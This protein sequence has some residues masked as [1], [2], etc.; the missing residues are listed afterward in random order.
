VLN[1]PIFVFTVEIKLTVSTQNTVT[2]FIDIIA[3]AYH[4]KSTAK[5]IT[6]S[7]TSAG[8]MTIDRKTMQ[9]KH[10]MQL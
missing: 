6:F 2:C 5:Y 10:D 4:M 1:Q 8:A 7:R 3:A 9:A